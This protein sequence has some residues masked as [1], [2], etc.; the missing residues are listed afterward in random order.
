MHMGHKA[1]AGIGRAIKKSYGVILH[2][3]IKQMT[4]I[5]LDYTI[6]NIQKF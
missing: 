4:L 2:K 6:K 3:Y 1:I 5:H